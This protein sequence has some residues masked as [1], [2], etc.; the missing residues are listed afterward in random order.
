MPPQKPP[1]AK[2][3]VQAVKP[4]DPTQPVMPTRA[5]INAI[6]HLR[7]GEASAEDQTLALDWIINGAC[8]T[9]AWAWQADPSKKDIFLGR[10]FVGQQITAIL[11][12]PL[13]IL[14]DVQDDN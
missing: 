12:M 3:I 6:R 11:T 7:T 2:T 13:S 5:V 9:N 1:K 14:K 4:I 10:Q 8:L